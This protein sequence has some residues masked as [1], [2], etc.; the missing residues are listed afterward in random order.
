MWELLA[1]NVAFVCT[2]PNLSCVNLPLF[3]RY[4]P[5]QKSLGQYCNIHI[6]LP[7]LSSLLN[8]ASFW[9]M[10]C[11]SPSPTLNKVETRKKFWI[12]VSNIVCWV[13]GGVGSVWIGK[14]PR[15]ASVHDC[16]YNMLISVCEQS[17]HMNILVTVSVFYKIVT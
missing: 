13:R 11:S 6:F 12:Q 16:S 10:S 8:G 1:N 2:G 3:T 9:K 14:R 4:N 5:G 15:I 7:F 17:R